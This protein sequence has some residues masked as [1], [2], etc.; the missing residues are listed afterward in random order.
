MET[1]TFIGYF[2]AFLLVSLNFL[3]CVWQSLIN[4]DWTAKISAAIVACIFLLSAGV[5]MKAMF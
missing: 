5:L 3:L 1:L 2:V 4:Q